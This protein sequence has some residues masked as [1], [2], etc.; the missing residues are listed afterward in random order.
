MSTV[1]ARKHFWCNYFRQED[2]FLHEIN[3]TSLIQELLREQPWHTNGYYSLLVVISDLGWNEIE[4]RPVGQHS[5][6][7]RTS[8]SARGMKFEISTEYI[9]KSKT[10]TP[11][12]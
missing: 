11:A 5:F 8:K 1:F 4:D 9:L 6:M 2:Y 10:T 3:A 7:R 12:S